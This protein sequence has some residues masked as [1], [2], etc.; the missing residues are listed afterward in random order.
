MSPAR[1]IAPA[2]AF[3]VYSHMLAPLLG[4]ILGGMGAGMMYSYLYFFK[5]DYVPDACVPVRSARM[6]TRACASHS[7]ACVYCLGMPFLPRTQTGKALF[8]FDCIHHRWQWLLRTV[9]AHSMR[10]VLTW[11]PP[12]FARVWLRD[13][14]AGTASRASQ[15]RTR[16]SRTRLHSGSSST[17]AVEREREKFIDNQ[18]DD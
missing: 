8:W 16:L 4:T 17:V 6:R 10:H 12:R 13:V 14:W 5:P 2:V 11:T 7:C 15:A 1:V 3:G 9:S 18:I